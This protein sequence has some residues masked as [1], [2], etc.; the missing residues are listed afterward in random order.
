[1]F[2]FAV[3][4]TTFATSLPLFATSSATSNCTSL[5]F[6]AC[7]ISP[8]RSFVHPFFE[9]CLL[10][11]D[12][13]TLYFAASS[14]SVNLPVRYSQTHQ[15]PHSGGPGRFLSLASVLAMYHG[16]VNQD[17]RQA[18]RRTIFQYGVH[19]RMRFFHAHTQLR[20]SG[21]N[22]SRCIALFHVDHEK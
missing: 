11:A 10:T 12:L 6:V 9:I 1:M 22:L 20:R 16:W 18:Q 5:A 7:L 2:S 4:I 8:W 17:S 19:C 21:L 14:C 13:D 3:A 15:S